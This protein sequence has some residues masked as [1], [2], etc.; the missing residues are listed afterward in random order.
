MPDPWDRTRL[1]YWD[2]AGW[3]PHVH[4]PRASD[5][6][7]NT[8]PAA[9][10]GTTSASGHHRRRVAIA[11][12]AVLALTGTV[13]AALL[14][15]GRGSSRVVVTPA[16][17]S[18][19][20]AVLWAA[21]EK[22]LVEQDGAQLRTLET[23][24][25]LHGDE[26]RLPCQDCRLHAPGATYSRAVVLVPR[27]TSYPAR[28]LAEVATTAVDGGPTTEVLVVVR[29]SPTA[30][31]TLALD[32]GWSTVTSPPGD[33]SEPLED[34][35][36]LDLPPTASAHAAARR[37]RQRLAAYWQ[38]AKDAGAVPPS[39]PFVAGPWTTGRAAELAAHPQGGVQG[40][41]LLGTTKV[42]VSPKD[43]LYE[44]SSPGG[45]DLACGV[46]WTQSLNYGGPQ[47]YPYQPADRSNWGPEVP[48]GTYR[49]MTTSYQWQSCMFVDPSGQSISVLGGYG[50]TESWSS[51]R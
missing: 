6:W 20:L 37:A 2:G 7:S 47:G 42:W 50:L 29:R 3:T 32:T 11:L 25:A 27:Q 30:S 4:P 33:L 24:S 22:A 48:P 23:G 51:G 35:A 10:P 13:A 45:G 40:N 28:F 19:A 49:E 8:L 17:A 36:G 21:R 5:P 44:F 9:P 12:G 39:G 38:Q 41:G 18:R 46:V 15:A 31:W 14:L 1:R 43:P 16:Q 26:I 34:A